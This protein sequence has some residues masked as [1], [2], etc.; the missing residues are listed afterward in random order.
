MQLGSLLL[1][2]WLILVGLTWLTWVS[3][4]T[5]FLGGLAAVTGIL[6]LVESYHPIVIYRRP[7]AA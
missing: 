5:Q 6:L 7:P 4:S 3:I 2:I 1:A